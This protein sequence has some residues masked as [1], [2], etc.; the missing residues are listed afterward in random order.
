MRQSASELQT[1]ARLCTQSGGKA[2][3]GEYRNFPRTASSGFLGSFTQTFVEV[4]ATRMSMEV[5]RWTTSR[6]VL[7]LVASAC[8]SFHIDGE[9]SITHNTS[10]LAGFPL[11]LSC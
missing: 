6:K 4:T 11:S 5:K 10:S 2:V 1:I 7:M 3:A 9:S 8:F